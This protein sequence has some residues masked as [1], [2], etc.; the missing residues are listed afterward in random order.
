MN[1]KTTTV[2]A[3][4]CLVLVASVA[5]AGKP[6]PKPEPWVRLSI[7][8]PQYKKDLTTPI[9]YGSGWVLTFKLQASTSALGITPTEAP[10][11][12]TGLE[13]TGF[14]VFSDP[15]GCLALPPPYFR[16]PASNPPSTCDLASS[17]ETYLEFTNDVDHVGQ[18]DFAGNAARAAALADPQQSGAPTFTGW[19]DA[20]RDSDGSV[21]TPGHPQTFAVGPGTGG[22]TSDGVGYGA[23]DDLPGLVVLSE[24]GPGRVF[25]A[26]FNSVTPRT[27]RNLAGFLTW[28]GSTLRESTDKTTIYAGMLIPQ[29]LIA[30]IMFSDDCV[31]SG[32]PLCTGTPQYRV[33]GGA[34]TESTYPSTQS[35][36]SL[37]DSRTYVVRAFVVNGTAPS[38]LDDRDGDGD[39]DSGDAQLA[40]YQLISNEDTVMLRQY[41]DNVCAVGL[42]NVV[43]SDFDGNG[44]AHFPYPCPAGPGQ[45]KPPPQ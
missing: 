15:D 1:T 24:T 29:G 25:N 9:T 2:L 3:G 12:Y 44:S 17:D 39:V 38:I 10:A 28:V 42:S 33:D 14:V 7:E 31:G 30:P 5:V 13:D 34:V 21:I 32:A 18:P 16:P 23:D 45:I 11:T 8:S 22:A 27:Q 20:V 4:A 36:P 40:G 41:H 6:P 37:F 19:E 26:S 43:Y 35:Y